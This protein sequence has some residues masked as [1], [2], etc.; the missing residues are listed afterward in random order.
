MGVE[1]QPYTLRSSHHV[2]GEARLKRALQ[3]ML[4]AAT[5]PDAPPRFL[6]PAAEAAAAA[7]AAGIFS[8]A[9]TSI[10]VRVSTRA[11]VPYFLLAQNQQ[12]TNSTRQRLRVR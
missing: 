10:S 4:D 9:A 11:S 12:I 7:Q 8:P 3:G 5:G 6:D 1:E 2:T